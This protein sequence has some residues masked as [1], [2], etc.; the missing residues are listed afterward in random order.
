MVD[1]TKTSGPSYHIAGKHE[2]P[3]EKSILGP[4]RYNIPREITDGP[5]YK[6]GLAEHKSDQSSMEK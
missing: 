6:F 1:D 4:G 5:K 2:K 3:V